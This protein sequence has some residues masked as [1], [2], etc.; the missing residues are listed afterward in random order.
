M[1]KLC[2]RNS[3]RDQLINCEV[4]QRLFENCRF[5]G[6]SRFTENMFHNVNFGPDFSC[7]G[8]T[9]IRTSTVCLFVQCQACVGTLSFT[10]FCFEFVLRCSQNFSL[11]NFTAIICAH[12]SA[13]TSLLFLHIHN[14]K[15][16]M[17]TGLQRLIYNHVF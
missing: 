3:R 13:I 11:R 16:P 1:P 17:Q 6:E 8:R 14:L 10:V 2:I 15:F 4:T 5:K 12:I 9:E 7:K